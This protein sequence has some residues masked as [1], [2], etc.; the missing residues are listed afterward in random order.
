MLG[1]AGVIFQ[2]SSQITL[3]SSLSK[4]ISIGDQSYRVRSMRDEFLYNNLE[5]SMENG[6]PIA[7]PERAMA[8]LLY[9]NPHY[10][11]DNWKALDI[12]KV[13]SIQKEV[14]YL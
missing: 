7:S 5:I 10:Y 1:R 14:G 13:R 6:I 4:I 2:L 9:F 8:D 3:V 11:F 12:K